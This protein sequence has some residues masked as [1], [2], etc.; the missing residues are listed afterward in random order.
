VSKRISQDEVYGAIADAIA[1]WMGEVV[2][3]RRGRG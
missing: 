2:A 3:D 1:E